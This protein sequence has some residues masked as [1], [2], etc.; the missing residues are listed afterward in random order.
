MWYTNLGNN[1]IGR[2]TTSGVV[3]FYTGPN[4]I[5]PLGITAGPDGALWF[6]NNGNNTIGRITT[7][8]VMTSYGDPSISGP[9]AITSGP[10]GALWFT[11][12]NNNSIGRITTAGAV[13][14]YTSSTISDPLGI[15]TGPDGALWFTNDGNNSI[16]RITTS[17]VITDYTSATIS[18]PDGIAAGPDGALWF[19]NAGNN[20]IGR[21]TTSGVV[22]NYT[23]AT[24]SGPVGITAGPDG[25]MWFANFGNNSIG[26]ITAGPSLTSQTIAF[27]STAPS[28]AM[29]G[30][31]PYTVSATGGGSGNPVVFSIAGSASSVCSIAGAVV[32]LIGP[33]R[34]TIDANQVG[35]A[36]Y[37]AASQV[38]QT[39]TVAALPPVIT[40]PDNATAS[41]GSSF[42]FAVTTTGDPVPVIT[43]KGKLPKHLTFVN[44]GDGTATISGTPQ[45]TGTYNFTIKARLGKGKARSVATQLFTLTIGSD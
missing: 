32:S 37:S 3:S 1:V 38:Q 19:T 25:A 18:D 43:K 26:R 6:A 4:V 24:I 15:T 35:D 2:V 9:D 16:G 31:P 21:I 41:T 5:G 39:F 36:T 8:G 13:K 42:S 17:G 44:N 28:G 7:A 27:T 33:G 34:C 10:D 22:T 29:A 20:S 45:T 12:L 30:D 23:S 11:N 40:S 14:N